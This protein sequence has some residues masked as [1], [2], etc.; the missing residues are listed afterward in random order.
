MNIQRYYQNI[1][2]SI[3]NKL[4]I[5][6]KQIDHLIDKKVNDS[7]DTKL[8]KI[9]NTVVETK[10]KIFRPPIINKGITSDLGNV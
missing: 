8:F 2:E 5:V 3:S 10:M 6:I 4:A 1:D 7:I 9:I